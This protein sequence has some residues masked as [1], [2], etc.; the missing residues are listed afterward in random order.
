[1]I[2][3]GWTIDTS[4]DRTD[5]DSY[6]SKAATREAAIAAAVEYITEHESHAREVGLGT[7]ESIFD[8]AEPMRIA[9]FDALLERIGEAAFDGG[10]IGWGEDDGPYLDDDKAAQADLDVVLTEWAR[11]HVV[12]PA[13]RVKVEETVKIDP[14]EEVRP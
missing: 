14:V 7:I 9:Y 11:R 2:E 6:N 4:K 3:I 8:P 1:M 12:D 13:W 10:Y 5:W